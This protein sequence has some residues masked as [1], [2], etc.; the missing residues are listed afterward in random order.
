MFQLWLHRIVPNGRW[1]SR[2]HIGYLDQLEEKQ[3]LM[4]VPRLINPSPI[5]LREGFLLPLVVH[6]YRWYLVGM[7]NN[8]MVRMLLRLIRLL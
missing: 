8:Q 5:L 2:Q 3:P 6:S 1:W 7:L 4:K